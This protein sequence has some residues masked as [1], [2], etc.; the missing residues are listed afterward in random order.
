[1]RKTILAVAIMTGLSLNAQANISDGD[2]ADIDAILGEST[3]VEAK[4]TKKEEPKKV[5]KKETKK[6]TVKDT[7]STK[8]V[9]NK[10]TPATKPVADT[11]S[12]DTGNVSS[13]VK[14]SETQPT[15][16]VPVSGNHFVIEVKRVKDSIIKKTLTSDEMAMSFGFPV[17][18]TYKNEKEIVDFYTDIEKGRVAALN[19]MVQ[20]RDMLYDL[21]KTVKDGKVDVKPNIETV[22]YG[23]NFI[24]QF[25]E[26]DKKSNRV[27]LRVDYKNKA[28]VSYT[29]QEITTA[30]GTIERLKRPVIKTTNNTKEFWIKF[31]RDAKEKISIDEN[32]YIEIVMGRVLPF[33]QPIVVVDR[34]KIEEMRIAAEE[35]AKAAEKSKKDAEIKVEEDLYN[36][37][38]A[39]LKTK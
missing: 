17:S 4:D 5:E 24:I 1:M 25:V 30:D 2:M 29:S 28:V 22:E 19:N 32:H 26:F 33:V 21:K 37:L 6:E 10:T 38:E 11:K 35:A 16:V 20:E 31:E 23:Y 3:A 34:K 13:E 15:I 9:E 39:D 18:D 7:K 14:Q 36:S 27:K 12:V 8:T